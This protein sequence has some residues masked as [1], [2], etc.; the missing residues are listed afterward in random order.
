[1]A[2]PVENWPETDRT[3][4][5]TLKVTNELNQIP[6]KF[7]QLFDESN[8]GQCSGTIKILEDRFDIINLETQN[9]RADDTNYVDIGNVR[10]A[11]RKRKPADAA[12]LVGRHD[13]Q[14]TDVNIEAVPPKSLAD[15]ARRY[16]DD[17]FFDPLGGFYG[18]AY[19]G[20]YGQTAV[21]FTPGNIIA[22]GGAGITKAKLQALMKLFNDNDVDTETEE[23][24]LFIDN[25]GVIDLQNITEFANWEYSEDRP[26]ARGEFAAGRGFLGFRYIRCNMLSARAYPSAPGTIV[27]AAGQISL[28]A[29]VPSGLY[30]GV[31]TE[32]FYRQGE[33]PSKKHQMQQYAEACSAITRVDEKKCFQMVCNGR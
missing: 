13:I 30:R 15:A 29:F 18:N 8:S 3:I 33:N 20:E 17:A 31:W 27:P 21:P 14:A 2:V 9:N 1:M 12:V 25:Q 28:P 6:G 26:L 4:A 7:T 19:T 24:I 23:P 32:F 11:I 5:Y 10:R 22:H 16:H